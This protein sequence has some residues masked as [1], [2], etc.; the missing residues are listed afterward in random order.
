MLCPSDTPEGE[1]CVLV[2]I[3][4]LL[5]DVTTDTDAEQ[6]QRLLYDLGVQSI[7]LF[8]GAEINE[9]NVAFLNR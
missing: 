1:S 7:M 5:T 3:L 6:L 8:S 2:K 9:N 4:A